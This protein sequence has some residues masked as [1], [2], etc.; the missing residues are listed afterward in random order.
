[1]NDSTKSK[2]AGQNAHKADASEKYRF[3]PKLI[4]ALMLGL[5]VGIAGAVCMLTP[6]GR[7]P[8]EDAAMLMRYSQHLADGQG[9]VWNAGEKPLDGATDFLFMCTTAA[10]YK[11]SSSKSIQESVAL[12]DMLSMF[13]MGAMLY[14]GLRFYFKTRVMLA[15]S[16]AVVF[17]LG[18]GA[19]YRAAY[20]GTPFFAAFVMLS[21]LTGLHIIRAMHVP[22]CTNW[23]FAVFCLLMGLTRPEGVLLAIFILTGIVWARGYERSKHLIFS[24]AAVFLVLGG[25]YFAWRWSYFGHPLPNPFYKKGGGHLYPQSLS[26]SARNFVR[27]CLPVIFLLL[28]KP[29][30]FTSRLAQGA[31]IPIILFM[32]IW[33]LLSNEMNY[34]GRFQY[35]LM[36]MFFAMVGFFIPTQRK[37]RNLLRIIALVLLFAGGYYMHN[38]CE[39]L[40][41]RFYYNKN[42][43]GRYE[44]AIELSRYKDRGYYL[45]TTEAGLL[46]LYSQWKAI[47]TWGLNDHWIAT[48]SGVTAE[49]LDCYKPAVIMVHETTPCLPGWDKMTDT[50]KKYAADRNY[51][52]AGEFGKPGKDVHLYYVRPDL[53]DSQA[54][55]QT[56]ANCNYFWFKTSK[57]SPNFAQ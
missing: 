33:V 55:I 56:I 4:D 19:W 52:L 2:S 50:L 17:L 31:F 20:F 5:I 14:A 45:A 23:A 6:A 46:P 48:N 43:D 41:N 1:M 7:V 37:A 15:F 16:I 22:K 30:M 18:P 49:Y 25:A 32:G 28:L 51:I 11:F 42:L 36:V 29:R 35:P 12:L 9:I 39:K 57:I 13:A 44:L 3:N 54:L 53:P 27:F 34:M 8:F 38:S 10:H 24:F 40:A 21:Y 47:D 26:E